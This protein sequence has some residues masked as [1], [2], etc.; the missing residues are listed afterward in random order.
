[1]PFEIWSCEWSTGAVSL[2]LGE[3]VHATSSV[4]TALLAARD[5]L[6]GRGAMGRLVPVTVIADGRVGVLVHDPD[7]DAAVFIPR[8]VL[9]EDQAPSFVGIA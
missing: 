5:Y 7:R 3:Q 9:V 8:M 2:A 1:M 4:V 6:R